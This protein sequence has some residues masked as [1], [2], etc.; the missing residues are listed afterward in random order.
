MTIDD[1]IWDEKLQYNINTEATKIL[2]WSTVKIDECEYLTGQEIL[3]SNKIQILE[4]G[5]FAYSSLEKASEK[6]TKMIEDQG[7]KQVEALDVLNPEKNQKLKSIE[8]LFPKEMV[9]N[10]IKNEIDEIRKWEDKI[11]QKNLK[12]KTNKY[13]YIILYVCVCVCMWF[14]SFWNNKINIYPGKIISTDETAMDQTNLLKN[15]I[16]VNNKSKSR[17]KEDTDKKWNTFDSV[18]ALYE[19]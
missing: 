9:T 8:E 4:Q 14:S 19:V 15:M 11:K 3:P 10:E 1:K 18:N 6:Q 16:K 2:A 5:K 12:Y 7:I 13:I 17:S